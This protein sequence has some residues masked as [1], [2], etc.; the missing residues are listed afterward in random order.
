MSFINS[1]YIKYLEKFD[2][3]P[4]K[5]KFQNNEEYVIGEGTPQ[6]EITVKNEISKTELLKSTSIALGEAYMR[7]DIEIQG[8]LFQVLNLFLSQMDKFTTDA[9]SLKNLIFTSSS[10]KNQKSEVQSHYDIG[11]NFYSLWLDDTMTYSC[12]YFKSDNDSLHDAQI[13]KI[14]HSLKK[15]NLKEGM[16]LLDIGCGWGSLLIE[17]AKKYKVHGLGIT[18]SEEQF[19]KCNER[20]KEEKLENLLEVK[21]MDY[22]DLIKSGRGFDRVIS[23]GMLEHV[24]RENYELFIK[25]VDGVLKPEGVFLLHYISAL[26]EYPGDPWIKKYVFKG[27]VIPSL[28]E[29]INICGDYKFYVIDVESLR[30]HYVKT[31]LCWRDN[32]NKNIDK[33]SKMF[34][35]EF[36]RMWELYLSSCAATFNNGIIDLHQI[37]IT[38]GLNNNIPMTRDYLY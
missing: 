33:I 20:I 11:N 15:L 26:K 24:G 9:K 37:L 25:N 22:R 6:F 8:D 31:L 4:F 30:R 17:A 23:I 10:P 18:L 14:N 2:D 21:L 35:Q 3:I 12:G 7:G 28:R 27:G 1:F 5:V 38:K 16:S 34:N 36:I 19:K 13:N 29:I 32:Y